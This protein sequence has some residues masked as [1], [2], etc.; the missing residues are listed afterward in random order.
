MRTAQPKDREIVK[1]SVLRDDMD[2]V[3]KLAK[4]QGMTLQECIGRIVEWFASQS[5]ARRKVIL[6]N[7]S[8]DEVRSVY[9]ELAAEIKPA[10][11]PVTTARVK[12]LEAEL[13]SELNRVSPGVE[14]RGARRPG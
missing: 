5:A 6:G 10:A 2:T 13:I 9:A 8:D 14:K 1:V 11:D 7:L 12:E 4:A 3:R